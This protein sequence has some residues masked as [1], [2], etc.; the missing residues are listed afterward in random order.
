M[1]IAIDARLNAYHLS[2]RFAS[3]DLD[4]ILGL[5]ESSYPVRIEREPGNSVLTLR[6]R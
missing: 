1:R 5:I 3:A 2:G 4:G 6:S